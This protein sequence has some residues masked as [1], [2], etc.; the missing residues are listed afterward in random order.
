MLYFLLPEGWVH[1]EEYVSNLL[2]CNK[3]LQNLEAWNNCKYLLSH[4]FC[5]AGIWVALPQGLSWGCSH[6]K[7]PQSCEGLTLAGDSLQRCLLGVVG[8]LLWAVDGRPERLSTE[9]F[10]QSACVLTQH[11]SWISPSVSVR[12]ERQQDGNC[13][14]FYSLAQEG[15]CH[16]LAIFCWSHK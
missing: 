9:V 16:H 6:V 13:S 14:G 8:K 10:P 1:Q 2:L 12:S 7:G 3:L 15:P 11:G 5:G 4:S